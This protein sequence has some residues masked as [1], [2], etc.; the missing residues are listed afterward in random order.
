MLMDRYCSFNSSVANASELTATDFHTS[1]MV[2]WQ[3]IYNLTIVRVIDLTITT[4]VNQLECYMVCLISAVQ[5]CVW[6][7]TAIGSKAV[8]LWF[9]HLLHISVD[10]VQC[11][12]TRPSVERCC[13]GASK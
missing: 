1:T 9:K 11:I 2:S 10:M 6:Y 13:G 8:S 7:C 3:K 5:K 4:D 12:T